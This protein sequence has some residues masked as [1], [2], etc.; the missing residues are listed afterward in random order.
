MERSK[1]R[2]GNDF[3]QPGDSGAPPFVIQKDENGENKLVLLGTVCS[4]IAATRVDF[5]QKVPFPDIIIYMTS[6]ATSNSP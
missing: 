3:I 2:N 6:H 5:T 1:S 4:T